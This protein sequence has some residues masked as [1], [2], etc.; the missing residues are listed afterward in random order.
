MPII[1]IYNNKGGVG[2]STVTVGLAEFL[3]SNLKKRVLVIDLDAQASTSCALIGHRR[4]NNAI[5]SGMS[6]IDVVL[7]LKRTGRKVPDLDDYLIHRPAYRGR[8][9]P[10]GELRLLVPDKARQVDV[11]DSMDSQRDCKLMRKFLRPIL[12]KQFDYT[13]IDFPG[14][15]DRRQL[16]AM[17]GL[18][19]S[20]FVVVP[21]DPTQ[22]TLN[23]APETFDVVSQAQRMAGN[24]RPAILGLLRNR[25]DHRTQQARTNI[26]FIKENAAHGDLPPVFE[27]F[28]PPA[29]TFESTTDEKLD[30]N[31]LKQ[32]YQTYYD[33]V[34]KVTKELD[35]RCTEFEFPATSAASNARY[36]T[37]FRDLMDSFLT[38]A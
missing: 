2:K 6:V 13:L 17:N 15:L 36:T 12:E 27:N 23:A 38:R 37:R 24:G 7:E 20:D 30:P 25:T 14:N 10:L 35:R 22:I 28:L 29:P 34:R 19:M 5:A 3:S 16:I 21:I 11:E 33:H 18:V 8:G 4:L 31:T 32:K 9:M 1:S 26:K